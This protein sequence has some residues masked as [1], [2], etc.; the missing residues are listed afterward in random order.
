MPFLPQP[1]QF[2]LAWYRH[3]IC[4]LAYPMAWFIPRG[5]DLGWRVWE[6]K[7]GQGGLGVGSWRRVVGPS[8]YVQGVLWTVEDGEGLVRDVVWW[9]QG[10]SVGG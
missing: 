1:S 7:A 4:W 2:I 6:L 3:R 10:W 5:L 8:G 9:P